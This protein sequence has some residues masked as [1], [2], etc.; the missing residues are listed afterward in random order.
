MSAYESAVLARFGYSAARGCGRA[1][2]CPA[3]S[4]PDL[5]QRTGSRQAAPHKLTQAEVGRAARRD[6]RRT[7]PRT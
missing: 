3:F 2:L 5:F 4:L 1:R 6:P 7:S